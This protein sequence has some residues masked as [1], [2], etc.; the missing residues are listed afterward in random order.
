[1]RERERERK[2]E[3]ERQR[4]RDRQTD[5]QTDTD[6]ERDRQTDRQTESMTKREGRQETE[7][8]KG[9]RGEGGGERERESNREERKA[10][11]RERERRKRRASYFVTKN[12]GWFRPLRG[13]SLLAILQRQGQ[14]SS[15]ITLHFTR[16]KIINDHTGFDSVRLLMPKLF[17]ADT[18]SATEIVS[19]N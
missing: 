15:M 17:H 12:W 7:T 6:S 13:P 2:R 1:M 9:G 4:E 11:D 10:R 18:K 3:R 16:S 5:R 19:K 14:G 8:G